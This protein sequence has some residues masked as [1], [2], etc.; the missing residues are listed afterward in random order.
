LL[1]EVSKK[2]PGIPSVMMEL[3]SQVAN[4]GH[5][6]MILEYHVELAALNIALYKVHARQAV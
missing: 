2:N 1:S 6:A 5:A 4:S 3:Q